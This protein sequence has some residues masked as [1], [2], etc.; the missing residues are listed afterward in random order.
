MLHLANSREGQQV[1]DASLSLQRKPATANALMWQVC[2]YP[3]M[4][5][6]VALAIYWQAARLWLKGNVFHSHP[7]LETASLEHE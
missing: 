7:R 1:F 4:T 3:F 2:R 5:A 6:K